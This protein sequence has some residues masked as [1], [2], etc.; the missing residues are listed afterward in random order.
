MNGGTC[1][2]H[3]KDPKEKF[4]CKCPNT[5]CG[6]I[7]G[8]KISSCIDVFKGAASG[9]I[10]ANGTYIITRSDNKTTVPVYCAFDSPNQ[11]WTLIE[12]FSLVNNEILKTK[13]F[14]Q[15]YPRKQLSPN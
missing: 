10:P 12:S 5:H 7:C 1:V 6:N 11:A 8:E 4:T 13:A 9:A 14:H 15:N 2:E 3:C